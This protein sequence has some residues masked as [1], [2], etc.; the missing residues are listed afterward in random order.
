MATR[1]ERVVLD[2]ESNL[3]Q[4]MVRD[5]AAAKLLARELNSLS[6][7]AVRS[8]KDLDKPA[9]S[10][11]KLDRNA[12]SAGQGI[13]QF[14]GRLR[15][16]S[17]AALILGP[18]IAPLG[19]ATIPLL[20]G[21]LVGLGA[22][23]GGIGAAV[24]AFSGLGDG[25]KAL[26][27][28]RLEPTADN[29][30]KLR[31]EAEKLGPAGMEFARYWS[32]LEPELRSIQSVAREGIFP[33]VEDGI[34]ALLTRGPQVSRIISELAQG[35]GDIARNSGE[36]LAS[37]EWDNFFDY[38][39]SDARPTLD[40]FA[41]SIGNVSLGVANM[42]VAFAPLTRDFTGGLETMTAAFAE[43]S[44]TL[45]TNESFQDFVGFVRESGPQ[46]V[47]FLGAM[48]QAITGLL[49]AAAPLGQV[50]LPALTAMA[51]AFAAIAASPIGPPLYTAIAAIV[52]FD[53][54]ATI[55]QK[56]STKLSSS[57]E[58]LGSRGQSAILGLALLVPVAT[59]LK[60][61][62][63]EMTSSIEAADDALRNSDVDALLAE[64][65]ALLE[66][67]AQGHPEEGTIGNWWDAFMG[68]FQD[69]TGATNEAE[70]RIAEIG[71]AMQNGGDLADLFAR[72]IGLTGDQMRAA[73]GDA[74][75]FSGAL[76]RLNGW[77]DKRDAVRAYKDSIDTL[78]ESLKDGFSRED[79]GN[80]D[81]IGRSILQVAENIKNPA[82]R[83][84]F[85][86]NARGQLENMAEKSGPRAAAAI[87]E[88]ID[89]F[90]DKGLTHPPKVEI[91]ADGR[92]AEQAID[93]VKNNLKIM[94]QSI[95]KPQIG[96]NDNPFR[97]TYGTVK[98][99]MKE[100]DALRATPKV[101]A[102]IGNTLGLLGQVSRLLTSIN[103]RVSTATIRVNR[104]GG[105]TSSAGGQSVP[106][107]GETTPTPG[108]RAADRGSNRGGGGGGGGNNKSDDFFGLIGGNG[109]VSGST[110]SATAGV[111]ALGRASANAAF[112]MQSM[113]SLTSIL[114]RRLKEQQSL[115]DNA[116]SNLDAATGRR[117]SISSGIQSGLSGDLW[118][119]SAGS[120]W[121]GGG[122]ANP[123]AAANAR[124]DRTRRFVA[125]LNTL[126]QKGVTGPAL[127]EI[128]GTGDVERA[129][130][131]AALPIEQL[132]SFSSTLNTAN[133]ELAAAGLAGGNAIE[134]QNIAEWQR[135]TADELKELREIKA[136][137]KAADRS[138]QAVPEQT[139]QF[140]AQAVN[141]ATGRGHKR[142]KQGGGR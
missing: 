20:T 118:E 120:V 38:V 88:V 102:D 56:S 133:A 4:V 61:A 95:T 64:R 11:T 85:L 114:N 15:A 101:E 18:T 10:A 98:Q 79:A 41:S 116:Q 97:Q 30:Q 76:A 108:R 113:G 40:A 75:F 74:E 59:E 91:A 36:G 35:M 124:L 6:G 84:D 21:A 13:N 14:T 111:M 8:S 125:A 24:L 121:S 69:F 107:P 26:D 60:S 90:D 115:Y 112:Q 78:R 48:A 83:S 44:T 117:D 1:R 106:D 77:F 52:A 57:W 19:A 72:D 9:E 66:Q 138:N 134:G 141:G 142:G 68:S 130:M 58:R 7:Q 25:L 39:E 53:R 81:N 82:L 17:E 123:M 139:G 135:A 2:V 103:G 131:M 42:L 86:Q 70:R 129:E 31:L 89:K 99:A 127:L 51:G 87:Q 104:V 16:L 22:A 55:A 71:D 47:A 140:V 100:A 32:N 137:I 63:D 12:S 49:T 109:R 67:I 80:L 28:Y 136:A 110:G 45:D 62:Y 122:V 126:R 94:G 50:V 128:I 92:R 29:L 27:A 73:G 34:D 37:G 93:G 105:S 46:A 5:A 96:A 132:G 54:A 119:K 23:A 43:W 3:A 65:L 33:G